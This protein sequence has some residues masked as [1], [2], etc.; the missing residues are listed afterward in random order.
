MSRTME[1]GEPA[2]V[3]IINKQILKTDIPRDPKF[4]VKMMHDHIY[5]SSR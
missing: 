4:N 2:A 3:I 1:T 5:N